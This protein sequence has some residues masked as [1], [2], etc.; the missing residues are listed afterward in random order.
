[1]AH[2]Y[3]D[4]LNSYGDMGNIITLKNRCAW[5]GIDL[6]IDEIKDNSYIQQDKYD[7]V[8][9]G[10]TEDYKQLKASEL[11]YK[12]KENLKA[13]CEEHCVILAISGGYQLLG[14]SIETEE[15]KIIKG[16]SL[17][18]IDTKISKNHL[19][20]NFTGEIIELNNECVVGFVNH[21][22]ETILNNKVKPLIKVK[23]GVGNQKK[24]KYEGA[25]YKNT[26]GTYLHGPILPKNPLFTDYLISLALNK[27]YKCEI[28]LTEL[29]DIIENRANSSCF[30][31]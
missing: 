23:K 16:I 27:K 31:I 6:K 20:G 4:L 9:I 11:L 22:R 3:P 24:S 17:L 12:N 28:P 1:M 8:F 13:M 19:T 25:R 10:G 29:D 26:F 21:T 14:N 2:L 7:L 5:R 30:N 18:D 15:N